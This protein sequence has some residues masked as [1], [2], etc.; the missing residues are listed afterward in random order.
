MMNFIATRIRDSNDRM[1]TYKGKNRVMMNK[2]ENF[3]TYVKSINWV[4]KY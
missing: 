3:Y 2:H 4:D 1:F